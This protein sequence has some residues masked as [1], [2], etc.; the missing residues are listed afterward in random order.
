MFVIDALV[1]LYYLS[2]QPESCDSPSQ[3]VTT[4][5]FKYVYNDFSLNEY[6]NGL[7]LFLFVFKINYFTLK[8]IQGNFNVT[9]R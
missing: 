4:T 5:D 2:A 8:L 6:C 3:K 9:F 1:C 7:L